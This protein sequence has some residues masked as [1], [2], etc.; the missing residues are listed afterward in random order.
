MLSLISDEEDGFLQKRAAR[1]LSRL[2]AVF[3]LYERY[4]R[5]NCK[6]PIFFGSSL[7]SEQTVSS[8]VIF[9]KKFTLRR[10]DQTGDDWQHAK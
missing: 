3:S 5:D 4:E 1:E 8:Q 7:F 6:S 2:N 9:S 10:R